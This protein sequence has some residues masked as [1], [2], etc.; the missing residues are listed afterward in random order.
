MD[1][2]Y[3]LVVHAGKRPL[4]QLIIS[5]F[6]FAVM[7]YY[8]YKTCQLFYFFGYSDHTLIIFPKYVNIMAYTFAAGFTSSIMKSVLI[9]LDKDKLVS[10]FSIGP[11]SWDKLS[12]I[13]ELKYVSV[14]KDSN[15]NF[16]VNLWYSGNKHYS[17]YKFNNKSDA[18]LLAKNTAVILKIDL[19]DSTERGDN[20]WIDLAS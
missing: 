14:F 3:E 7:F 8:I 1:K 11:F 19:L 20:K 13:P 6:L 18:F 4:W 10:R 2:E 5:A 15:E 9:D 17:M 12:I 16:Q